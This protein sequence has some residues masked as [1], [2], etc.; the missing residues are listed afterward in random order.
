MVPV[1]DVHSVARPQV[2][3]GRALGA[4]AAERAKHAT[5]PREF[6][7]STNGLKPFDAVLAERGQEEQHSRDAAD[8]AREQK[9]NAQKADLERKRLDADRKTLLAVARHALS[10]PPR[11]VEGFD[12]ALA[13][14]SDELYAAD[15]RVF[16]Q[17][18]EKLA[19]RAHSWGRWDLVSKVEGQYTQSAPGGP[20]C[21]FLRTM[22]D[23]LR[24][25]QSGRSSSGE[26]AP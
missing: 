4:A 13:L 7:G 12:K 6:T 21:P 3:I 10:D 14:L 23:D 8:Q 25:R 9:Q 26:R 18:A 2:D 17:L 1:P 19:Y 16:D 5:P 22:V 20:L 15:E 11:D 24:S